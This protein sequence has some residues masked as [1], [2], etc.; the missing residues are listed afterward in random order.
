M[1]ENLWFCPTTFEKC[2]KLWEASGLKPYFALVRHLAN[3][4]TWKVLDQTKPTKSFNHYRWLTKLMI[5]RYL[6]QSLV[7]QQDVSV[8]SFMT[9]SKSRLSFYPLTCKNYLSLS[10]DRIKGCKYVFKGHVTKHT[11]ANSCL[12]SGFL[13]PKCLICKIISSFSDFVCVSL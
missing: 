13:K 10:E 2:L 3:M 4:T 1:K 9:L 6:Y 5:H 8:G 11:S 7:Q 12:N